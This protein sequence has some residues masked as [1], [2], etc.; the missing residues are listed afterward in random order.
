MTSSWIKVSSQDGGHYRAYLSLPPSGKGPGLLVLQEIFG[1]NRHIRNVCDKFA[2]EGFVVLA[3]ELFWRLEPNFEV[4]YEGEDFDRALAYY[5]KFDEQLGLADIESS[6]KHLKG[7]AECTGKIGVTGFCL[8][9][10]MTFHSATHLDIDCG[11]AYYGGGIQNHLE[12]AKDLKCPLVIHLG[13]HDD[14]IPP[15]AIAKI[16]KELGNNSKVTI[17]VYEGAQHGFNCDERASYHKPSAD[18]AFKR[19]IDA[20]KSALS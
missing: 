4:G 10:K 17:Y 7:L 19:S 6:R 15:D 13:E 14:L 3:P 11:V 8:G 9:G 18:L 20:L 5:P 2:A 12:E 16:K 1:V